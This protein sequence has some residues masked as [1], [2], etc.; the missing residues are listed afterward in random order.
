M[1]PQNHFRDATKKA[2]SD[3]YYYLGGL[4]GAFIVWLLIRVILL[5]VT[6]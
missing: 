5:L 1:K 6:K 3:R 4:V 2:Y